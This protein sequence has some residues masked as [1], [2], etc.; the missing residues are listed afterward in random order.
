M[1]ARPPRRAYFCRP[2]CLRPY[3]FCLMKS[4]FLRS[5]GVVPLALVAGQALAQGQV[6]PPASTLPGLQPAAASAQ[7]P[8]HHTHD[9]N[10]SVHFQQTIIQQWHNDL[11][12]R[13]AGGNSLQARENAKL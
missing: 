13:Y 10:W 2:Y 6:T 4:Y 12:P 8:T 3:F 7:E 11:S 1:E 9:E 5:L